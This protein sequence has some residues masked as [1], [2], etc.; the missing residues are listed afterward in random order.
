[1][2]GFLAQVYILNDPFHNFPAFQLAHSQTDYIL[3]YYQSQGLQVNEFTEAQ[4]LKGPIK[5]W[6]VNYTDNMP[7]MNGS[8]PESLAR[9]PPSYI[10]WT[11]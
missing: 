7:I 10:T 6:K 1:M 11:F 8:E 4:G 2:R 3:Q 9:I 5:I